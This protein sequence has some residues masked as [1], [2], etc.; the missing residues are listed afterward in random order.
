M[1]R[2]AYLSLSARRAWIEIPSMHIEPTKGSKSLSARRAWIEICN[3]L[4]QDGAYRVALRKESV[5]RNNAIFSFSI[6][7]L[8]VALRKESVDRNYPPEKPLEIGEK[9]LSARR[10][11]IEIK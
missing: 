11:W 10:A 9:S 1:I 5:D 7:T 4:G 2:Q 8:C 6:F 3:I